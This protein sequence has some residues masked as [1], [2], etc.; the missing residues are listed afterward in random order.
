MNKRQVTLL[1]SLDLSAAF[2][3][4]DHEILL[5]RL[6]YKFGIKHQAGTWFKSYLSNSSQRIVNGSAKSDSFDLKFG[7]PQGP[8]LG[9]T[10]FSLYTSELFDVIRHNLPT[11]HSYADDTGIYLAFNPND[12][13][14]QDA[15]IAA[16]EACLCDIRNWMINDKLI[17]NDSK[18]EF[19]LIWTK[20]QLQETKSATLTIGES[21]ISITKELRKV[22]FR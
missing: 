16:M 15:T 5:R 13:S 18:T 12:G 17:I 10:L 9:P 2:D 11:A 3:T 20:A 14:D 22:C 19:M 6:E 1:V 21:I 8:C 4:A 7:V